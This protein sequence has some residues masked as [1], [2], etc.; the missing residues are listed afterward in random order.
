MN[1]TPLTPGWVQT[2]A[3]KLVPLS[4]R[5]AAVRKSGM[6]LDRYMFPEAASTRRFRVIIVPPDFPTPPAVA[7]VQLFRRSMRVCNF[8]VDAA[9]QAVVD[10]YSHGGYVGVFGVEVIENEKKAEK[11]RT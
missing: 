6:R 3:I 7:I 1:A 9:Y 11:L 5:S 2:L 8:Y 10:N 4:T